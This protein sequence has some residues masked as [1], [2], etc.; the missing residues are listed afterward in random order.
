MLAP[1]LLARWD[2]ALV[3]DDISYAAA[4]PGP[5]APGC[6]H[7]VYIPVSRF[8]PGV[9]RGWGGAAVAALDE[10]AAQ[11][12]DLLAGLA[13]VPDEL[14]ALTRAKLVTEPI[15]DLRIDFEDGFRAHRGTVADDLD[16]DDHAVRAAGIVAAEPMPRSW[17]LRIR[18]L[19]GATRQRGLR[20][21]DLFLGAV[22][23]A[24][25]LRA[26]FVV[27][28]PKVTSLAQIGVFVAVLAQLEIAHSLEPGTL[29]FEIQVE[30]PQTVLGA[31]GTVPVAQMIHAADGRVSGLHF[32]TYDYT[33]SLG[34]LGAHQ[35]LRHP[36]ADFAKSLMML[37]AAETGVRVSDGSDNKV[38][39]GP[40]DV[41]GQRWATHADG[42][43]RALR[44]GIFQGWDLHAA[45]LPSRFAATFS[46]FRD[47]WAEAAVRLGDYH[48]QEPG[49]GGVLDEPATAF[50]LARHLAAA[51][52]CG[53]VRPEEMLAVAGI[54]RAV[55]ERY[56]VR[57][58]P[59]GGRS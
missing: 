13:G 24:G 25:P 45:Q 27:T 47:G 17:G 38:P 22:L 51:L 18:S 46:F 29:R 36:V 3:P 56:L 34:I 26:G 7:T 49:A 32:G 6:V 1:E 53:A 15:E 52:A 54:D 28:L 2:D 14:D 19:A 37:A 30:T 59:P 11:W 33:A 58:A 8:V 10:H 55:V 21:L 20:T 35:N 5:P 42:V 50:A 4:Y 39:V 48:R 44:Q 40:P 41:V 31:D 16:E 9:V 43:L 23:S 12:Q 57:G